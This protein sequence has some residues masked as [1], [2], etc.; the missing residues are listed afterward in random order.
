MD[1]E[2]V[3]LSKQFV[4]AVFAFPLYEYNIL[5]NMFL[6]AMSMIN[7]VKSAKELTA[8]TPEMECDQTCHVWN[9]YHNEII[10]VKCECL[11]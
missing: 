6:N 5:L 10:L 3:Y 9:M 7:V 4:T 11:R 8:F 2:T 1:I